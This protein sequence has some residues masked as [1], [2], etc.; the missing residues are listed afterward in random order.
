MLPKHHAAYGAVAALVAAPWLGGRSLA[1][2]AGS[3]LIDVDHYLWYVEHRHDLSL[4]RAYRFFRAARAG[5]AHLESDARPLHGPYVA[6]L[7]LLLAWRWPAFRPWCGGILVH[8]LLDAYA[9]HRLDAFLPL[10]LRALA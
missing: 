7:F 2:W 5:D 10:R 1:L 8:S 4:P 6:A 9:E 3:I